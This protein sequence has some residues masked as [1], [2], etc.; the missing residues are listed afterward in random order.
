MIDIWAGFFL[1]L[2]ANLITR[3]PLRNLGMNSN[4]E[5]ESFSPNILK[6]C[7]QTWPDRRIE[8]NP[9][10]SERSFDRWFRTP[11]IPRAHFVSQI[12]IGHI[13]ALINA[14]ETST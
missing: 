7:I 13:V 12:Q 5:Q 9:M 6:G 10:L 2:Q 4:T 1:K 3:W 11:Q 14:R 8:D